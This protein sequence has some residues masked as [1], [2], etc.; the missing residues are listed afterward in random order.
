MFLK[1]WG[2]VVTLLMISVTALAAQNI[3]VV[4]QA[5]DPIILDPPMYSDTPTHNVNLLVYDRLYNLSSD[6]KVVPGL[7]VDL[8]KIGGER[9][10]IH[11]QN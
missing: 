1:K 6:G 8:P 11:Y 3:L 10:K 9:Y 5:T 4:G 7:A 2:A